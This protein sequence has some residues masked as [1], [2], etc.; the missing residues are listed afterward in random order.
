MTAASIAPSI[1]AMQPQQFHLDRSQACRVVRF[2]EP[3]VK[4]LGHDDLVSVRT[5]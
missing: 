4:V 3:V 2:G 1:I 5:G